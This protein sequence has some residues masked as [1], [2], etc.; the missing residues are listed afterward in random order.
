MAGDCGL[1]LVLTAGILLCRML[2]ATIV[3]Q[4]P[5]AV[6]QVQPVLPGPDDIVLAEGRADDDSSLLRIA[7]RRTCALRPD[8]CRRVVRR[9]SV[10]PAVPASAIEGSGWR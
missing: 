4:L 10:K 9:T 2:R 7:D 1:R 3:D 5:H 6:L 8:E